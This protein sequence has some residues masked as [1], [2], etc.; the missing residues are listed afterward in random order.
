MLS[1]T[2]G[3]DSAR[4][5]LALRGAI[6]VDADNA[7]EVGSRTTQ[8]LQTLFERND[9]RH[10]ELVSVFFTATPDIRSVAPGVAARAFGL[11]EVP[12]ICVQEMAVQGSLPLCIRIMAHLDTQKTRADLRHVFLR[13]A[14]ALRPEL[15]EP[16]DE[17]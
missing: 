8:L 4:S 9:L 5:F 16:G 12:L 13:G 7:A 6:T 17:A 14:V 1:D 3:A 10:E 2:S 11:T 15:A